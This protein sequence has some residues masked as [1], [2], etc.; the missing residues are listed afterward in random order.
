M[1]LHTLKCRTE[2]IFISFFFFFFSEKALDLSSFISRP[3][4]QIFTKL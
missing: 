2:N 1:Y 4:R 3:W